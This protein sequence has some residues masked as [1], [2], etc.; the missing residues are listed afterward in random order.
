MFG[1]SFILSMVL[2]YVAGKGLEWL[3][4]LSAEKKVEVE[5]YIKDLVSPDWLDQPVWSLVNSAWDALLVVAKSLAQQ[6]VDG[7]DADKA[8]ASS[9]ASL[10]KQLP[11]EVS[12]VSLVS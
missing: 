6:L 2:K 11:E 10:Q 5:K 8:L 1:K 7:A 12:S 3:E 4:E 9:V